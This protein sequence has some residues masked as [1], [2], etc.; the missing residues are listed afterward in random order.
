MSYR[1]AAASF[2]LLLAR[3]CSSLPPSRRIATSPGRAR[4]ASPTIPLMIPRSTASPREE[5][6]APFAPS[7]DMPSATPKSRPATVDRGTTFYT[8][9]SDSSGSFA[10]YNIPPG[11]YDVTVSSGVDEA[12]ERVQ[13][14]PAI[15]DSTVD[16]RLANK[17]RR[18]RKRSRPFRSR[19]TASR[20]GP[21]A[22]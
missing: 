13:V 20:Q 4:P 11:T 17:P 5:L 8:T 18:S 10:L 2:S 7:T 3:C 19:S 1:L 9:H 15:G 21:R 22:L 14:G 16:I 12:H 6:P